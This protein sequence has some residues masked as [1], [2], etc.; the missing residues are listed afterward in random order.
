MNGVRMRLPTINQVI[1]LAVTLAALLF[2]L[3]LMPENF[4]RWFRL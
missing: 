2:V 1:S 3:R 4:K